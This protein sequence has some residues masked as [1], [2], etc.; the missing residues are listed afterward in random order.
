MPVFSPSVNMFYLTV[1]ILLSCLL[2]SDVLFLEIKQFI[3]ADN[4][5]VG[6]FNADSHKIRHG[7]AHIICLSVSWLCYMFLLLPRG[8]PT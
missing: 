4:R 1:L 8:Y 6:G 5:Y 7:F 3:F 2:D